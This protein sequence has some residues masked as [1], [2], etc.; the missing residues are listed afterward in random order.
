MNK[1]VLV[2]G[3]T[4]QVGR[5]LIDSL[6]GQ[7][8]I[9]L[10]ALVRDDKKA[11]ALTSRGVQT[12]VGSLED[13]SAVR[14]A[15]VGV[16]TVA[17]IT[18]A[19]AHAFEQAAAFIKLA[20]DARVRKI[21]RLSAIK[22]AENGPTDNTRQHGQTERAIRDS[23]LTFV[24]LRPQYYMQNLLGGVAS[25]ADQGK[26]YAGVADAKIGMI[27]SRDVASALA[28]AVLS[29]SFNGKTFEVTGPESISHEAVAAELGQSL[30]RTVQYIPVSPE[31][32]GEAVRAFG[33]DDWTVRL[34]AD[35]S[36]AY[37]DGFG[38]FIT[39]AV[40][41]LT[42]H[43]PRSVRAFTKEVFLPVAEHLATAKTAVAS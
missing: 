14:Q 43:A 1:V 12:I 3:G 42:G 8:I 13:P 19:G 27:D 26:L 15:L 9:Q 17:L 25:I 16:D 2:V 29:E 7:P 11:K 6:T 31:A 33:A 21:V 35:Y 10:R 24:V 36:R 30:K 32:A 20:V 18:P 40:Q 22:A 37:T 38:D 23:G 41:V 34:I 5:A 39:D 4:G 28:A